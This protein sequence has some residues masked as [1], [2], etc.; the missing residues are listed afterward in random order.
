MK[1]VNNK[2]KVLFVCLGNIC[3]SPSAEAVFNHKIKKLKIETNFEVDSAG[4]IGYHEGEK[5][6]PRMRTH[7]KKRGIELTSISRPVVAEDFEKF[8][9][10]I[11]MDSSNMKELQSRASQYGGKEK[12]HLMTDFS[13]KYDY[14]Y[15]P[16]PY[17]GGED[18]FELVLDLL[19]D[20]CDELLEYIK[21][22]Q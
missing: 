5:A 3:R 12:L 16:D 1:S 7:A 21:K 19:D 10:I 6:D 22:M 18:G 2:Y 11:G 14:N 17:Y 20:A 9:L 13:T 8:D 4:I 15:V